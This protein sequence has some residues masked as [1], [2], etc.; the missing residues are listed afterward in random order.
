MTVQ[1]TET[2][3]VV[4]HPKDH[5]T[6]F[7]VL[8]YG[9]TVISYKTKGNENL[10]LSEAAKLDGSKPVRG[11]IPLV[12]PVFGKESDPVNPLSKL[13][14]HG[15]ARNS[16]WEFLGES[17]PKEKDGVAVQFGLYPEIAN[18]ELTKLWNY[19]FTL[20]LTLE[21]T[22]SSLRTNIEVSNPISSKT[23]FKFH[24]LFHTY[25]KIDDI[26]DTFITNLTG[27]N[28]YDQLLK[29]NYIDKLPV[30][31]FQEEFDKIY[32]NV[33]SSRM[34]QIV[35]RGE[36]LHTVKRSQ[37]PDLVVWNPWIEKSAGM[38]DFEPKTGFKNMVCVEA[39][40]VKNYIDLKPGE[41]WTAEQILCEEK[42]KY[43]AI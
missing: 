23:D 2:K 30:I 7:T 34:V 16:T 3:V 42:L 1:E 26:E 15:L 18:E 6:Q 4:S 32:S 11:G 27:N 13:P 19:D 41:K 8:K 22:E 28:V 17:S 40:H 29:E 25:F 14:Q 20:I 36:V 43:Q 35:D 33:D 9:A 21:L 31:Q 10:F 37:L 12:F 39:G 24:W 38:A 5:S